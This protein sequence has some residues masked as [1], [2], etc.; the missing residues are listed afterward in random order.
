MKEIDGNRRTVIM[1]QVENE[2][3]FLNST[4]ICIRD[5]AYG[6]ITTSVATMHNRMDAASIQVHGNL[7]RNSATD[8]LDRYTIDSSVLRPKAGSDPILLST[9]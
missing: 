8:A 6:P 2:I 7:S 3:G 4:S 5:T 9:K 1:V